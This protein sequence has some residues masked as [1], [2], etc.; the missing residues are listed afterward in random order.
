MPRPYASCAYV[1][2]AKRPPQ[3]KLR[4]DDLLFYLRSRHAADDACR[5]FR[6]SDASIS[7]TPRA[8]ERIIGA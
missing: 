7:Y 2:V 4:F 8:L 5:Q 3:I 6:L 1:A